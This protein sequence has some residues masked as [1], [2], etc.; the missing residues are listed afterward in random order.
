MT[1]KNPNHSLIDVHVPSQIHRNIK[2]GDPQRSLAQL[3][4]QSSITNSRSGQPCFCL[5]NT[6]KPSMSSLSITPALNYPPTRYF[7]PNVWFEFP[8]PQLITIAP[9]LIYNSS[10]T[11]SK[12]VTTC[13]VLRLMSFYCRK[14]QGL[15]GNYTK[16][17][18]S[19]WNTQT[20]P[21]VYI[22][23]YLIQH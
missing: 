12:N 18:L 5:A 8:K 16:I 20:T 6:W 23:R 15:R 10:F 1:M 14:K 2:G 9:A 22:M 4:T 17:H 19:N 13:W 21:S 11:A 3:P 7:S